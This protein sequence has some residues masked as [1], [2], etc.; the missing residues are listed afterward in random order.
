MEK[1]AH[2]C[3]LAYLPDE[4]CEIAVWHFCDT[5]Q[6]APADQTLWIVPSVAADPHAEVTDATLDFVLTK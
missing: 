6:L 4:W 5:P 3:A 1:A 2:F